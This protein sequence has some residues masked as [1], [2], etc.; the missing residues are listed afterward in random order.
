[1]ERTS[2]VHGILLFSVCVSTGYLGLLGDDFLRSFLVRCNAGFDSGYMQA[3]VYGGC[4][5]EFPTLSHV[6]V[7]L[8]SQGR[9]SRSL[10]R[11]MS[12][13]NC[14]LHVR[15]LQEHLPHFAVC[16]VRQWSLDHASVYGSGGISHVLYVNVDLDPSRAAHLRKLDIISPSPCVSGSSC[17]VSSLPEVYSNMDSTGR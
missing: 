3:S 8:G 9:C 10:R 16:L 7:D 4:V 2:E 11:P 6:K 17:S 15:W 12:T 1:M 5:D 14:I 13:R